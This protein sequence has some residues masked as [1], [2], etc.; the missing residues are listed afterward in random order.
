MAGTP[1]AGGASSGIKVALVV[2]VVL[3]VASLTGTIIMY[4]YLS[5]KVDAANASNDRA[6]RAEQQRRDMETQLRAFGRQVVGQDIDDVAKIGEAV[7]GGLQPVV[8]NPALAEANLPKDAA[9]LTAMNT[10]HSQFQ[11]QGQALQ[12]I[13]AE[14]DQ[15]RADMAAMQAAT[16]KGRQEFADKIKELEDRF[17]SLETQSTEDRSAWDKQVDDLSSQLEKAAEAAGQQLGGERQQRRAIE[18]QLDQAKARVQELVATLASFRPR[19][20]QKSALKIADGQI[21]RAVAGDRLVYINLGKGDG[22]QRGMTFSVY[23]HSRPIPEDGKGKATVLVTEVYEKSSEARVTSLTANDPILE[24]DVV[25]NP[26]YDRNRKYNFVVAGDF[27]LNFD[28]NVD[29]PAGEQVKTMIRSAGGNVVDKLDTQTD[30]VVLG[31]PP[32]FAGPVDSAATP[33]I[34]ELTRQRAARRKTF[35]SIVADAKGLSIPILTR[36]QFLQFVGTPVPA[37]APAE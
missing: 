12:Q 23:S 24:N 30:F 7:K 1:R 34:Q 36:T 9:L 29:D 27:D 19:P 33:Q 4:T 31:G 16:D 25:A 3:T 35:D 18:K 26:V 28:G 2:F 6:N 21:V 37:N 15:L 20:D 22:I 13:T 5:D 11:S 8:E 32:P 10:L 14:R 17:A